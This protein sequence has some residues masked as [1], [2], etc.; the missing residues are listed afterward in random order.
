MSQRTATTTDRER[1]IACAE[2]KVRSPRSPWRKGPHCDTRA[3][4]AS[5]AQI[6]AQPIPRRKPRP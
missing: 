4:R 3:A 6:T 5:F 1:A 2:R